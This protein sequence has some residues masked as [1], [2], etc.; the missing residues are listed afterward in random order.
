M[1]MIILNLINNCDDDIAMQLIYVLLLIK[2]LDN[3]NSNVRLITKFTNC[4]KS[5][6][7]FKKIKVK[8]GK[9]GSINKIN[10]LNKNTPPKQYK[11]KNKLNFKLPI[12]VLKTLLSNIIKFIPAVLRINKDNF[13]YNNIKAEVITNTVITKEV[14]IEKVKEINAMY[15]RMKPI[16][17]I[18]KEDYKIDKDT[19]LNIKPTQTHHCNNIKQDSKQK[20]KKEQT[21]KETK[22]DNYTKEND[23]ITTVIKE[24]EGITRVCNK[25]PLNN[26]EIIIY[27]INSIKI[28]GHINIY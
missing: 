18:H 20:C 25:I 15:G 11:P 12:K 26:W 10:K 27:H 24:V 7:V 22:S 16:S 9:S 23:K 8:N 2:A 13:K 14:I 28:V 17:K 1:E 19:E 5:K 6:I 3:K 21:I 4:L